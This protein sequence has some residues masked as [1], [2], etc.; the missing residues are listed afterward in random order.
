M[1]SGE[2]DSPNSEDTR[3]GYDKVAEQYTQQYSDELSHKPLDRELL[4]R[5]AERTTGKGRVCD[6]GCGPGHLARYLHDRGADALGIDL[7]PGM[8][9]QARLMNPG[10]EYTQGDMRA[11]DL[12]DGSLAGIAAFYSIIHIPRDQVADVLKELRRVL[13]PGGLLLLAFHKGQETVHR[14]EFFGE[15]VNLDF[16]FFEPDEM[17]GYLE[18]AGFTVDEV[19]VREPYPEVEYP[20]RRVSYLRA[21]LPARVYF[22]TYTEVVA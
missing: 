15:A 1:E 17:R 13:Q 5:F 2:T 14:D 21:S 7:S 20:S 11:L 3:T 6:L 8:V 12:P 18:D 16:R 22:Q 19:I 10:I 4:D 9:E